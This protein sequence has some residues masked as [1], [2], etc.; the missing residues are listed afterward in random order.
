MT[1]KYMIASLDPSMKITR[2]KF[3]VQILFGYV[4]N[5]RTQPCPFIQ[6]HIHWNTWPNDGRTNPL[7]HQLFEMHRQFCHHSALHSSLHL[8][9]MTNN[10][11][12][13]II[14]ECYCTLCTQYASEGFTSSNLTSSTN[15]HEPSILDTDLFRFGSANITAICIVLLRYLTVVV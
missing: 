1:V 12:S 11:W 4:Y 3:C 9:E 15:I 5:K 13:T 8:L 7:C 10:R 6:A 2:S 14:I